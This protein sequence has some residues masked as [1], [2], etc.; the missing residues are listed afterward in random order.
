MSKLVLELHDWREMKADKDSE[1]VA[2]FLFSLTTE[3]DRQ[4]G[5]RLDQEHAFWTEVRLSRD[6]AGRGRWPQISKQ[7]R[8]RAMFRWAQERIQ[9]RGRK[10]RQAPMFWTATSSLA[11]GP[12][13]DWNRSA[14]KFPKADP[15]A[16]ET[17]DEI[18][19]SEAASREAA[20]LNK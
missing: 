2:I 15:V 7:D 12:P 8:I 19:A 10:L 14:F 4:A 1:L 9:Q 5:V 20:G 13:A 16:F 6:L 17:A 11:D 18:R 3:N